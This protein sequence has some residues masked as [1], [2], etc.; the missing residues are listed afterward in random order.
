MLSYLL[1]LGV[2]CDYALMQKLE[3]SQ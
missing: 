1:T 2:F 3:D